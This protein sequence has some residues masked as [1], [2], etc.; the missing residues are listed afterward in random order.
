MHCIIIYKLYYNRAIIYFY[1][2]GVV[3]YLPASLSYLCGPRG[4]VNHG[5][6]LVSFRSDHVTQDGHS[7]QPVLIALVHG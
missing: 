2:D 5:T 1:I 3:L 6:L 4:D 7:E